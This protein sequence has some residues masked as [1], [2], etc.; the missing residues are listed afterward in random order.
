MKALMTEI[1]SE[2]KALKNEGM[3]YGGYVSNEH[4]TRIEYYAGPEHPG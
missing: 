3:Q 2:A 4:F 1:D